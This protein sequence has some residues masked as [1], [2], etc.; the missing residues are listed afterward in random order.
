M[1][2]SSGGTRFARFGIFKLD[3]HSKELLKAGRRIKL[4]G[5]PMEV[6]LALL[7]K[8][9]EVVPRSELQSRLWPQNTYVDFE[10]GLIRQSAKFGCLST[11]Q[12]TVPGI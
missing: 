8:P 11:T 12:P 10:H 7:E 1:N 3:T 9:G 5:Q 6:L 4:H 2:L